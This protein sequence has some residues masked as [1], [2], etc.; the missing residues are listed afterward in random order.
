MDFFTHEFQKTL[1]RKI[2]Y[3]EPEKNAADSIQSLR[4]KLKNFPNSLLITGKFKTDVKT[5]SIVKDIKKETK[6][7]KAF[8]KIELWEMEL[9]VEYIDTNSFK[10]L[11]KKTIRSNLKDADPTKTEF[12]FKSLFDKITDQ[13]LQESQKKVRIQ[14]RYL[15]KNRKMP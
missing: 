1:N 2:E 8:V 7:K 14:V 6:K 15:L 12:N 10:T 9:E 13:F 11:G 5:R 4:E 3:F